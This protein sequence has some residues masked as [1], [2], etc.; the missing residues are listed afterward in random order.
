V[1]FQGFQSLREPLVLEVQVRKLQDGFTVVGVG[2]KGAMQ[3]IDGRV[4]LAGGGLGQG[5]RLECCGECGIELERPLDR[6]D[7]VRRSP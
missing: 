2:P 3:Q 5:Q 4:A 1:S 6:R 7:R